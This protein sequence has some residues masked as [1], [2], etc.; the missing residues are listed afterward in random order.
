MEDYKHRQN[1]T[2]YTELL[3]KKILRG[4]LEDVETCELQHLRTTSRV[5]NKIVLNHDYHGSNVEAAL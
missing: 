5:E 4:V 2:L 3:H 1:R